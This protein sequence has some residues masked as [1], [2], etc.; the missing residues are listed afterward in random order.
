[1]IAEWLHLAAEDGSLRENDPLRT[2]TWLAY[3]RARRPEVS[4]VPLVN[5]WN[6]HEWEGAKLARMLAN[7][8]SAGANHRAD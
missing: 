6:G 8:A 5:N 2:A 4:M 1:V 3:I 7:P